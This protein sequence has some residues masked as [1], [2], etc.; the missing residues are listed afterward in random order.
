MQLSGSLSQE[1]IVIANQVEEWFTQSTVTQPNGPKESVVT[2][3]MLT[4][5]INSLH[6]GCSP[7]VDGITTEH[8]RYGISDML[9]LRLS[10]LYN[11]M[12][13]KLCVP[14]IFTRGII[15]PVLKKPSLNPNLPT[16]YR[17]ITLS[18]V[19]TKIIEMLM[20]P[21]CE[22]NDAQLGFRSGRGTTFGCSLLND[23]MSYFKCKHSPLYVCSLD[24]EKCFDSI[25]HPALF[26][27]L[28]DKIPYTHW[29]FLI[30]WYKNLKATVKWEGQY[31]TYFTITKGTR[32]GSVL[33]PYLFNIFID[34]LLVKLESAKNGVSIGPHNYNSFAYADDITV[35]SATIPGLQCLIH[36]CQEYY[37]SRVCTKMAF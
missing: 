21:Q 22:I 6:K 27:K 37:M 34:D 2:P 14:E 8:L 9:I 5:L 7:G 16:S 12:F 3:D 4:K 32:Q 35:F 31:S 30:K 11:T 13:Q 24:A 26:Y 23:I 29:V 10:Q 28:K 33:S 17:P 36:I 1:Q 18:S 19:H 15:I 20:L 25:W